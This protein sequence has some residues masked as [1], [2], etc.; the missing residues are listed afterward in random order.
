MIKAITFDFWDTIVV[1]DSDEPKR[2]AAGLTSKIETRL[3]LLTDE[4]CRHHPTI[5]V[6]QV[7]MA[8]GVAN[9]RFRHQW[10]TL[11]TTP[12][13]ASRLSEAYAHLGIDLTPGFHEL[14]R[15][16]EFMEVEISPDLIPG[17]H[18]ALAALAQRYKL[19]IISD[20]IHTPARGLR[21]ILERENLLQHF[22]HTVFSDEAGA[23]KPHPA[24][25]E[26][27]SA[28]LG[29]PLAEI[30]HIGDRE[31]NDV[32]GPLAMGMKA[33]LFTAAIDRDSARSEA[34]AV[35]ASYSE[36]P[37]IIEEIGE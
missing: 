24:V 6:E 31:S 5:S 23:A 37:R 16:F 4:I 18:E 36:L 14:V 7:D 19:G 29:V 17:V 35:C 20:T 28:G 21:Q 15:A 30:V 3:Q 1:D 13:A 11:H 32:A 2:L 10:K 25:F 33:I 8:F 27:A 26:Q 12:N 22:S 34:T 9:G